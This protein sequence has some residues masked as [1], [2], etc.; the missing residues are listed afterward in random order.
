MNRHSGSRKSAADA[1]W[2]RGTN[3]TTGLSSDEAARRLVLHGPNE[4][5]SEPRTPAWRRMLQQLRDPLIMVLLVAAA[6]TIATVDLS[7]AAVILLVITV[8]TVV[9]VVQEV[10]AEQAVM[11]LSAMSAPAARVVR[12]GE[13]RSVPAA[14]VVPGD[15]VLVAEGDIVPTDGDV[16]AAAL[17]PADES[18]LTGESVPVEKAPDRDDASGAVSAGTVIVRDHGRIVVTATGADSALGRIASLMGGATGPTP[19]QHRLARFGRTLAAVTVALCAAVLTLGLVRGQPVELMIVAAI[20]LA[21]A[22]VPESLPAVVTLALAL[23]A[24]R[25]ADRHA[26][27]L[28]THGLPGVA[29]G[30]EPVAPDTM[31]H[32]P[33]PPEESVLG[34]GLWLRILFM[35]AFVAMV[36]LVVGVWARETGRPWQS[37]VFHPAR[38]GPR[39]PGAP[40]QPGQPVPA[41]RRG[42][43]TDAPGSRRLSPAP[44]RP[45]GC[46]GASACRPAIAA[47]LS[48][49]GHVVMRLQARL[50][51]ER[52]PRVG[53]S[54]AQG[55]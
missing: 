13:E 29:L 19:L 20:S 1:D 3:P 12:D 33:R 44:T 4:I 24:R 2:P 39:L 34:A 11:A 28:L 40:R 51:P 7:D 53:P 45:V 50:R 6:L 41:G 36:T 38:R 25:M 31:G 43:G 48:G 14:E 49:L 52:P 9:G 17:L 18:S 16:S 8:N 54:A 47:V 46:R 42:R 55:S 21:V 23:G 37:M 22:A 26:I 15:L 5:P 32:P 27:V 35:G 30:A 10:R